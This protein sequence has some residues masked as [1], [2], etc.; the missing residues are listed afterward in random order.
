MTHQQTIRVFLVGAS[1]ETANDLAALAQAAPYELIESESIAELLSE[2]ADLRG[3]CILV[4]DDENRAD[5]ESDGLK[6]LA[7]LMPM[8]APPASIFLVSKGNVQRAVD[9]MKLGA[10]NVL[11]WPD[12]R[13]ELVQAVTDALAQPRPAWRSEDRSKTRERASSTLERLTSR[14]RS[15][16]HLLIDGRSNKT[17][18]IELGISERTVEVHR[19]NIMRKLHVSSFAA[20]IRLAFEAGYMT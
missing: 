3:A 4:S 18:G 13:T 6:L 10:T 11:A 15:V 9:A 19:A 5:N 12:R 14:E 7:E 1:R 8:P 16:L 17:I 2:S 20:L